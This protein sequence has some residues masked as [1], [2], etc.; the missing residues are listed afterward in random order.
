[1]GLD[2]IRVTRNVEGLKC[3]N[4]SFFYN[5]FFYKYNMLYILS[6]AFLINYG[7]ATSSIQANFTRSGMIERCMDAYKS[8]NNFRHCFYYNVLGGESSSWTGPGLDTCIFETYCYDENCKEV[9]T[10]LDNIH[11]KNVKGTTVCKNGKFG[12]YNC[13]PGPFRKDCKKKPLPVPPSPPDIKPP[14]ITPENCKEMSKCSEGNPQESN[15][16]PDYCDCHKFYQC[17][18]TQDGGWIKY[19][20]ICPLSFLSTDDYRLYFDSKL[21]VCSF[22]LTNIAGICK[23]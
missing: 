9:Y 17:Q 14:N 2:L 4:N 3:K 13:E 12:M 11:I 10:Y 5:F 15:L 8:S 6:F 16:I 18:P 23:K 1:M 22:S 7:I 19:S 20:K 21:K